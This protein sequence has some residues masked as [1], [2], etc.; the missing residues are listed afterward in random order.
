MENLGAFGASEPA[1]LPGFGA[2][3]LFQAR[4]GDSAT[5]PVGSRVG[6]SF[7]GSACASRAAA[8]G[9]VGPVG[10]SPGDEEHRH[11]LWQQV[12]RGS[13]P[14]APKRQKPSSVDQNRGTPRC[15]SGPGPCA[16]RG[17][18]EPAQGTTEGLPPL[19][20]A[21]GVGQDYA[22]VH[23]TEQAEVP[24]ATAARV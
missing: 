15:A 9:S 2:C 19:V 10:R 14:G 16:V 22:L 13:L 17:P 3:H 20:R 23:R 12:K 6:T 5:D 1:I 18:P 8:Q 4:V 7:R 11:G 21:G 24:H